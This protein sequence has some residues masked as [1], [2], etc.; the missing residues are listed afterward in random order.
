[1]EAEYSRATPNVPATPFT[2]EWFP[3]GSRR[4]GSA[5]NSGRSCV[6]K[7]FIQ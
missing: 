4:S 3:C 1:M 7:S 5:D 2:P 6:L